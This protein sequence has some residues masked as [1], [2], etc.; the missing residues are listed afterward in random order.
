MVCAGIWNVHLWRCV[1]SEDSGLEPVPDEGIDGCFT[2]A[3]RTLRTKIEKER[4]DPKVA[5]DETVAECTLGLA[6][7]ASFAIGF[8]KKYGVKP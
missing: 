7:L 1:M 2:T 6:Q 3:I 5:Y 4:K 8:E